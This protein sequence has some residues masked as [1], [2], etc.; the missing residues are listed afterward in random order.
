M[1]VQI[2]CEISVKRFWTDASG[3][4][5]GHLPLALPNIL[6]VISFNMWEKELS[7]WKGSV[8]LTV[9]W[10]KRH[11]SIMVTSSTPP[12]RKQFPSI[13]SRILT[14]LWLMDTAILQSVVMAP[15][16]IQWRGCLGANICW[17]CWDLQPYLKP[18]SLINPDHLLS[19]F[20]HSEDLEGWELVWISSC[21]VST[22]VGLWVPNLIW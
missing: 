4:I 20:P 8:M 21:V 15:V 7:L 2:H 18:D 5:W 22:Q 16:Y 19:T 13:F 14:P 11:S 1:L 10:G 17:E 3:A 12:F 9:S 6:W